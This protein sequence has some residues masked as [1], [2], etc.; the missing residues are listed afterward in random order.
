L[1]GSVAA[2]GLIAAVDLLHTLFSLLAI[3]GMRISEALALL[4]ED[5]TPDGLV[6]RKTKF[7]KS[8]I[9]PHHP[10]AQA[11]LEKYLQRRRRVGA[12]DDHLF[13]YPCV[14]GRCSIRPC[15][16]RFCK[17]SALLACIPVQANEVHDYTI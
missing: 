3:T 5:L 14:V 8:R 4:L 13:I 7:Q 12:T 6:I 9:L 2:Y 17:R 10:S 16:R 15:W 1:R 11:G